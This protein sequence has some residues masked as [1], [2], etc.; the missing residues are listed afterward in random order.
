M[1][2]CPCCKARLGGALSCSR[3]QADLSK[4]IAARQGS[5]LWLA[6]ALR[7]WQE[8]ELER[9][10]NALELSLRLHQTAQAVAF[11]DYLIQQQCNAVLEFLAQKHLLSAAQRLY[12]ARLLLPHSE[13]LRNLRTF[14]DYL[15]AQQHATS[16]AVPASISA[17]AD[18]V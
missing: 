18:V 6:D 12:Q 5:R 2:R 13:L 11:R 3:C 8:N 4:A 15:L 10:V 1:E 7:H 14:T 9:S 17:N 16:S